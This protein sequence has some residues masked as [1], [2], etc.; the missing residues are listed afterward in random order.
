[1]SYLAILIVCAIGCI[2]GGWLLMWADLT[3]RKRSMVA[4]AVVAVVSVIVAVMFACATL[5]GSMKYTGEDVKSADVV[6]PTLIAPPQTGGV[7]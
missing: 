4:G 6:N 5:S 2:L 7:Q 3:N 1:M